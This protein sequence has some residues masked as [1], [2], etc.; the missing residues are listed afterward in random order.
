MCDISV[1][2]IYMCCLLL[3]C[4]EEG[5]WAVNLFLHLSPALKL[6]SFLVF[7]IREQ[8]GSQVGRETVLLSVFSLSCQQALTQLKCPGAKH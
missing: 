4:V 7:S 2:Y 5:K 6:P 3:F 8:Q 1:S